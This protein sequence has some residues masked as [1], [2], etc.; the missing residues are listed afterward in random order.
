MAMVFFLAED[1]KTKIK[2]DTESSIQ[3][4]LPS[5]VSKTSIMSGQ[6]ASDEVIEGNAT[7]SISGIVTYAKIKERQ[8]VDPVPNPIELQNHIQDTRRKRRKFTVFVKDSGQPIL[9]DYE[10]CVISDVSF[11]V[12]RFSD[13]ITVSITFEQVFVSE[14]A[15]KTYLAPQRK[16]SVKPSTAETTD[17]GQTT[18]TEEKESLSLFRTIEER[19]ADLGRFIGEGIADVLNPSSFSP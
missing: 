5:T 19:G 7:I 17:S 3:V 2:L 9:E 16:E 10:N 14:T 1:N 15:R 4:N 11:V 6:T 13:A 8:G 12:D 18:K